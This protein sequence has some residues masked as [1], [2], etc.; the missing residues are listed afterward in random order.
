MKKYTIE[1]IGTFLFVLSIIGII[2]SASALVPVHI[3]IT[4]A[5]LVY[6]GG[7]I[8]GAHYNP[9]VTF[10]VFLNKKISSRDALGYIIAQLLWATLAYLVMTRWLHI[11]LGAVSLFGNLK[12]FFIAECI[13]TFALV[14]AVYYTS[15][16][17]LTA[18]NSYFGLAIGAVVT[19]GAVVVGKISGGFF[20]P[21]VLLGIGLFGIPMKAALAILAGQLVGAF[22]AAWIY[23]Y[24]VG[25]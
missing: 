25:K 21:A 7:A 22:W 20:N 8:S 5:A 4:L 24:V 11:S 6:M 12:A 13:F 23:R 14:S 19:V 18:G 3:G 10:G 15:I 9:A 16:N 2:Y 1:F 17:R